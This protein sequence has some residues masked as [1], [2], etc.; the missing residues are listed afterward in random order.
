MSEADMVKELRAR[1]PIL[2]DFNAGPQ[3]QA[4]RSGILSE[5]KPI[6]ETFS[7]AQGIT[8]AQVYSDSWGYADV[9]SDEMS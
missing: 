1:G 4:Y 6:S 5:E 3:F 7:P 8:A 2:V 9:G